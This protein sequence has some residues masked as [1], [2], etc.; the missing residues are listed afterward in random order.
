MA[1]RGRLI[2]VVVRYCIALILLVNALAP[3]M[4]PAKALSAQPAAGGQES[5]ARLLPVM[6]QIKYDPPPIHRP[7]RFD[8]TPDEVPSPVPPK[9]PIEFTLSADPSILDANGLVTLKV[10]IRN[11]SAQAQSGLMFT[12]RLEQGLEY[13][14]GGADS[15]AYDPKTQIISLA[16]PSLAAGESLSFEYP[17]RATASKRANLAGKL[18]VHVANLDS[19]QGNIHLEAN[20]LFGGVSSPANGKPS[21]ATMHT[22][23]GWNAL[24]RFSIYMQ[25]DTISPDSILSASPVENPGKGPALQFKLDVLESSKATKDNQG[26]PAEQALS[27]GRVSAASFKHPAFLEIDL[28]GYVDLANVP[29]GQS[30]YVATYDEAN[31]VWIKVPILAMDRTTNKVTV[32]ANHFSTWGAGLG[33]SLPQNGANVLLFDQ[34]YTSLFTGAARYSLPIWTPPGRA[35]MAPNISL[36]YSSGTVDGVLGNVQAPW[37]GEGWNIDGVEITR[38]I[39]TSDAGYGY[40]NSF[41]LTLNGTLYELLVDPNEQT[42]YYT[43]QGSFLYVERHND[44]LLNGSQSIGHNPEVEKSDEWWEVVTT[45]GTRYYLG[46]HADSE[47]LALMYGYKCTTGSPCT[48]PDGAYASSGYAGNLTNRVPMRW[49]VDRV[50]DTH[51]NYIDY[52]YTEVTSDSPLVPRFDRA[53]YL[54]T[55]AYTGHVGVDELDVAPGYYVKFVLAPRSTMDGVPAAFNLWDNY[56]TQYLN[57]IQIC[58]GSCSNSDNIV[59]KYDLGYA[60]AGV[61]DPNGTLELTTITISGR[62]ST[63]TGAFTSTPTIHFGY[64]NWD[65]RA[66][67]GT[68]KKYPYPRL[69]QIQNGYGGSLTYTYENDGRGSSDWYD[70]R[71]KQ[72]DVSN[73]IGTVAIKGYAYSGTVYAGSNNT[74]ALIGYTDVTE[75]IYETDAV[76]KILNVVHHFGTTGLDTGYELSTI[77]SDPSGK[78]LSKTAST[79]VTDNSQAPFTGWNYRYLYRMQSYVRNGSSLVLTSQAISI[80][81]PSTGNL[82]VQETYLGS[83]LLRKQYY[84]YW[85]N[86]NP[87]QYILDKPIRQVLVDAGNTI[88]S[89]TRYGYDGVVSFRTDPPG[90]ITQGELRLIQRLVPTNGSPVRVANITYEYDAFGNQ[91]SARAYRD[92]GTAGDVPTG[93]YE[94]SS[95]TYDSTDLHTYAV[96]TRNALDQPASTAYLYGVGLPSAVTDPNGWVTSTTYDGLGRPLS[97]TPP[98]LLQQ[99]VKYTYPPIVSGAVAAPYEVA[100][101]MYDPEKAGTNHYRTITGVYDGLGRMLQT[102]VHDDDA[103]ADLITTTAYNAQGLA[104]QQSLPFYAGTTTQYTTTVYDALGRAIQVTAPGDIDSY[105]AYDGLTTTVTDPNGNKTARTADGLGRMTAVQEYNAIGVY[106]TT[107]YSYDIAD[108]LIG[109]TDAQSNSTSLSYD[110]L[111]RKVG[112]TDPDMGTWAYTYDPIGNLKEQ[113]DARDPQQVL[114]FEYDYLNRL[115]VKHDVT[116]NLDL[117]TYTYGTIATPA[118]SAANNIGLRVGMTDQSGSTAWAYDDYGRSVQETRSIGSVTNQVS[119]TSADWLGRVQTVQYPDTEELTYHYD[120]LGRPKNFSSSDDPNNNL[121][122]LAYNA[123]SQLTCVNLK[124]GVAI[125]NIY[126]S[127]TNGTNRLSTRAAQHD[128]D[129]ISENTATNQNSSTNRMYFSYLYDPAGNITRID[130]FLLGETHSY[131]Y[132]FLNRLTSAD[133]QDGDDH[134]YSQI[135]AYDQ[136]GNILQASDSQ[137]GNL[138]F[139]D[140]FDGLTLTGWSSVVQGGSVTADLWTMDG[141]AFKPAS[142]SRS[143]LVEVNDTT[144][145]YV[146]S[147]LSPAKAA[148]SARFYFHPNHIAMGASDVLTL[149]NARTSTAAVAQVAL[150][151]TNGVYQVRAGLLDNT[152]TWQNGSWY[153]IGNQ[154]NALE[155]DWQAGQDGTMSFWVNG[156]YKQTLGP[157]DNSG[158]QLTQAR[159]GAQSVPAGSADANHH[160]Q[161][162]F[163]A[164]E[165][166]SS[167]YIGLVPVQASGSA[168]NQ[169]VSFNTFGS[170]RGFDSLPPQEAATPTFTIVPSA[171]STITPSPTST[172]TFTFTPGPSPTRTATNTATPTGTATPTRTPTGTLTPASSTPTWELA[173]KWSFDETTG[174]PG[175]DTAGNTPASNGTPVGA[176]KEGGFWAY[177][178]RFSGTGQYVKVVRN[179]ELEPT[180]GFVISM[181]AYPVQINPG[182]TYV[183][184]N[185]GGNSQ[186]YRLYINSQGYLVFHINDVV[187]TDVTPTVTPISPANSADLLGPILPVNT[188]THIAAVYDPTA[189]QMKLYLNG[190][191]VVSKLVTGT[192]SY[193]TASGADLIISDSTNPF[194]GMLDEIR[195]YSGVL[196]ETPI[197]D[198]SNLTVTA[199]PNPTYTFTSSPT[200][201]PTRTPTAT[202]FTATASKTPTSTP[203]FTASPT[204]T[205]TLAQGTP[206]PQ[207]GSGADGDLYVGSGQTYNINT[208]TYLMP[209]TATPTA[210]PAGCPDGGPAVAYNVVTLGSTS[211]VLSATPSP[212]CLHAR[213]EMIPGDAGD[214][215]LLI[216]LQGSAISTDN[217]GMYEFLHIA[218]ISGSQVNFTT[219]K[220]HWYGEGWRSDSNIGTAWG[221]QHVMLMRVP[222][223]HNVTISGTGILTAN[224]WNGTKYGVIAFRVS[225]TL[226]GTGS[227]SM[228]GLG[229]GSGEGHAN[230]SSYVY[231]GGENGPSSLT[232]HNG[233]GGGGYGTN[234]TTAMAKGGAAYGNP[235]LSLLFPGGGGG[236]GGNCSN[237]DPGTE[238]GSPGGLGGGIILIAGN[239]I[240]F[241][242]PITSNGTNGGN[243]GGG[244]GAGGSIR[245]EGNVVTLANV[246]AIGGDSNAAGGSGRI[247]VYYKTSAAVTGNPTVIP[248]EFGQAATSTPTPTAILTITP[249]VWA[250]SEDGDLT[251]GSG[252]TFNIN[253]QT[254]NPNRTCTDGG[255]AVAYQVIGLD[256]S[257]A[258]LSITP[259]S[260]CLAIGD[261]VM[262]ISMKGTWLSNSN[263]GSYEFLHLSGINGDT[264]SFSAPKVNYY[265]ANPTD[266]TNIGSGSG[267]Q[268]VVL[269]RVP[270]YASVSVTGTL[271]ANGWDGNKYGVIAMRA[272]GT[273]SGGGTI[274]LD[275]LGYRS[276]EGYASISAG[277]DNYLFGA[278]VYGGDST[279]HHRLAGAGGYGTQG[280]NGLYVSGGNAYGNPELD[281]LFPGGGGGTGGYCFTC[282]GTEDGSP[283]GAGGGIL[284]ISAQTINFTGSLSANGLNGGGRGGGAG[285]GGSIRLEGNDV[286][287]GSAVTVSGASL[288][289]QGGRGRIAVY[290]QNTFT[291]SFTPQYL[292]K[293]NTADSIFQDDLESGDLSAWSTAQPG[294]GNPSASDSLSYL[295]TY[296]LQAV[297]APTA[298]NAIYVKDELPDNDTQYRARFYINPLGVTIGAS[299]V[300]DILNG[301]NVTTAVFKVQLQEPSSGSYQVR[302]GLLDN[303]TSWS[304][305]GWYP[306]PAGWSGVEISYQALANDGEMSLWLDGIAKGSLTQIDNSSRTVTEVLLGVQGTV[307][308]TQSSTLYFDNFESR[309]YSYI[310]L[311]PPPDLPVS[312]PSAQPGW[313]AKTYSYTGAQPHAVSAVDVEGTS[314]DGVYTYDANG[315]MTCRIEQGNTFKQTYN[316]ENRLSVVQ[317]VTAGTCASP[318]TIPYQWDFTYDGDG[319]RVKQIYTDFTTNP[320]AVTV[321]AYFMAGAYEVTGSAVKKYYAIAGMTV[322]MHDGSA[323]QYLLTDHL[324]SVVAVTNASGTLTSQQRYLPFGGV[325][326]VGSPSPLSGTDMAFTGQRNL[327]SQGNASMGL[328]DFRARFYDPYIT[329]WTQPDTI[330]PALGNPQ[331]FNRYSYVNNSP[332]GYSD[333]TGHDPVPCQSIYCAPIWTAPATSTDIVCGS[334]GADNMLDTGPACLTGSGA[335]GELVHM[336]AYGDPPDGYVTNPVPYPGDPDKM[337]PNASKQIQA[338]M[339][340]ADDPSSRKVLICYSAGVDSCLFYAALNPDK[341]D[342][343]V[344]MGGG[345][346]GYYS[347]DGGNSSYYVSPTEGQGKFAGGFNQVLTT[348]HATGVNILIVSDRE[349]KSDFTLPSSITKKFQN[350][351]VD[352]GH[353]DVDDDKS[354]ANQVWNW[355]SDPT[356]YIP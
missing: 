58:Y 267:Q 241:S 173:A 287:L 168:L 54:D 153:T 2:E 316:A 14:P 57:Q 87:E 256:S 112:M 278:G 321:T 120:A 353:F 213:D 107:R 29:A 9:D 242:G 47:Q 202:I 330:L 76:T 59:R 338:D 335:P 182:T 101:E 250:S 62:T 310:G 8:P 342:T 103:N 7:D 309:R 21:M 33:T 75:T 151:Y 208:G 56:D 24:G 146:Q 44:A 99:G 145:T 20:A 197:A 199:P 95:T 253:T 343:L 161:L 127:G 254:H 77:S 84:E 30:V 203:T 282:S 350:I 132:D 138:L 66:P 257:W 296:G 201:T 122:S 245:A 205:A 218:S 124:N 216:N 97:I 3:T 169:T 43:K 172:P 164:F 64:Q 299:D 226:S 114:S 131:T 308:A 116:N 22:G 159:L 198:L 248:M 45:D 41:A 50:L 109:T 312:T 243:K 181:W 72:V 331:S 247:A 67:S 219:S 289:N 106:A 177:S 285:A 100:L 325:R 108:R 311:L 137:P 306:L 149:F 334:Q 355:I 115:T 211:A 48:T 118:G 91:I 288:Q 279:N 94:L 12:D 328:M 40:E 266:D 234:G 356:Y 192:I 27:V 313:T 19:D 352:E 235:Q 162:L 119:T 142:G 290:Y 4:R 180:H 51:D 268:R 333:P 349:S 345:Y 252:T 63:G 298:T 224:A 166:R 81:D 150:R 274:K 60:N 189:R 86:F 26:R 79:Y 23:G 195:I 135:F 42:R 339:I 194:Y 302:A 80:N 271:T 319:G 269:M 336:T 148:Y 293:G 228:S 73:G 351:S 184:L 259:A 264:V 277:G 204:F 11:H 220:V 133:A 209:G 286:Q 152:S 230:A 16:I 49:R 324:G 284:W 332:I 141:G 300:L 244:A 179:A 314:N 139:K 71:V 155:I 25:G 214:E 348:L 130:D 104:Y 212:G 125:S 305:T 69:Y 185:K 292:Q 262:L 171:A 46:R 163:D 82:A 1:H 196:L 275:G 32:Q 297:I 315:N 231:G 61:P 346:G 78:Q 83:T 340:G 200:L 143:L 53:S 327:D 111:G 239:T 255:D 35:G 232:H 121:A 102:K 186:D 28:A 93:E 344:L 206:D 294:S 167:S 272:A 354:L 10:F 249:T 140:D 323:L 281:R 110:W 307:S 317:K 92:Y 318:T 175:K 303:G 160:N 237:C 233:G 17:L 170:S 183:L 70:Y 174:T 34:P 113:T 229:Y 128:T 260:T 126:D 261:E 89:D 193:N 326:T 31:E 55:I 65:N 6:P 129:C 329:R 283:G 158:Q 207:W 320:A 123:L 221:K 18:W 52:T 301:Y 236:W 227:I 246:A 74:G 291:G 215:I 258:R 13:V 238:D 90:S 190:V 273:V 251:V 337:L 37:V 280:A 156:A 105:T 276:D 98:G 217:V 188:W 5:A 263:V 295:G 270:N 147:D 36:S 210:V 68:N 144:D 178:M 265:G 223:Y 117:A 96:E 157:I 154:W 240:N 222:N 347:E 165:S 176:Q 38:K 15:L 88:F 225:G 134:P 136:V 39:T 322:A 187:A 304:Y 85:P 341:V 191:L